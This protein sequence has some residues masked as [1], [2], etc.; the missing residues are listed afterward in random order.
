[1][2]S[3]APSSTAALEQSV[4]R[5][6]HVL[7]R[8]SAPGLSRS[9]ASV[10]ARLRAA[11]PQR[12]TDLALWESVSQPSM[13]TLVNRLAEQELVERTGDATDRRAVLVAITDAGLERLAERQRAR[14]EALE[15]RMTILDDEEREILTQA[16]PLLQRLADLQGEEVA[17]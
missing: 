2:V 7:L 13:T 10:L 14:A 5:L 8:E 12:V 11:G 1:M 6:A 3:S 17:R 4:S 15:F 16:A 9:A